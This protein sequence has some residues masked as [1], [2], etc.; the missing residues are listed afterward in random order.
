MAF[1][2]FRR[3]TLVDAAVNLVPF[4]IIVFFLAYYLVVDPWPRDLLALFWE[5]TLHLVP[6]VLLLLA[7]GAAAWLIQA[8]E[9]ATE[10]ARDG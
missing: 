5:V 4:G 8:D 1:L 7:T 2:R 10:S 9:D 6:L 3:S